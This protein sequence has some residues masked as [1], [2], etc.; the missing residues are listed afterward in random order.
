MGRR[1]P[2]RSRRALRR[3]GIRRRARSLRGRW[4]ELAR[5]GR[6]R[7]TH[8]GRRCRRRAPCGRASRRSVDRRSRH[9]ARCPGRRSADA[10]TDGADRRT[11]RK[12]AAGHPAQG[13][14]PRVRQLCRAG[15]SGDRRGYEESRRGRHRPRPCRSAHGTARGRRGLGRDASARRGAA[16]CGNRARD[17]C[18]P[19]GA[20]FTTGSR[21]SETTRSFRRTWRSTSGCRGRAPS[22][23]A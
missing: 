13:R 20:R 21:A 5:D 14:A 18:S 7:R 3:T 23:C 19:S 16:A 15:A 12:S 17:L 1:A 2:R 10:H 8:G 6:V 9:G 4:P 11:S 22:R